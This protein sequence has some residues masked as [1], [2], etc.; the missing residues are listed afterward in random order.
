M[1]A[2]AASAKLDEPATYP[3]LPPGMQRGQV[4]TLL[5]E[6]AP[7]IGL[8]GRR[9]QALL[10]MMGQ[11]RPS[12]WVRTDCEP[13]CYMAQTELARLL[14]KT[15]RAVR[16]DEAALSGPLALIEKRTAANGARSSH[17][18][19]GL[20]FT[21]LMRRVP[22]LLRLR[23]ALRQ[24]GQRRKQLCRLRS[25]F[26]RRAKL[27]LMERLSATPDDLELCSFRDAFLTWP[28]PDELRAM[29]IGDLEAH[30]DAAR[31][32]CEIIDETSPSSHETSGRP[33][34]CDRSQ[35][36]DTTEEQSVSCIAGKAQSTGDLWAAS[37]HG[38]RDEEEVPS[39]PSADGRRPRPIDWRAP[40]RIYRL[41]SDDMQLRLDIERRRSG[42]LT[43]ID[44]IVAAIKSLPELGI[45]G[46]AWEEAADAMGEYF[47]ALCVVVTDANRTH[48]VTAVLNPGGHLRAMVRRHRAGNLNL[49]GSLIGLD[50]RRRL[51]QQ[52]R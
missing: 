15:E 45:H 7:A 47:A 29:A 22:A 40:A 41:A 11:T 6:I 48:P 37:P 2:F 49:V 26:Y 33:E 42:R 30:I 39:M 8:S 13:V 38:G 9:L 19:L 14:G 3:A 32:L 4:E 23:D 17:G 36:Q 20:V 5:I 10:L 35:L 51:G 28:G 46:S 25:A 18:R 52:G 43:E 44:L 27:A 1:T 31:S 34:V 24:E 16:A 12:D 50:E 21:R